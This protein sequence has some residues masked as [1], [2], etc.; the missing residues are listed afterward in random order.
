MLK[1]LSRGAVISLV[2][3]AL[4]ENANTVH[5]RLRAARRDFDQAVQRYR[6]RDEWRLR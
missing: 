4:G 2:L 5:S 1:L 6:T 3:L